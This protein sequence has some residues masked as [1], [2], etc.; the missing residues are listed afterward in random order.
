MENKDIKNIVI[1]TRGK[2][3]DKFGNPYRAFKAY[4][5]TKKSGVVKTVW[6]S[7][8]VGNCTE[9]DCREWAIAC[10]NM[11]LEVKI[12]KDDKRIEQHHKKVS[13]DSELEKPENW[14]V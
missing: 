12:T 11:V 10:I 8:D 6:K 14:R 1:Y 7:M 3:R 5:F 4:V 9:S 13:R 2:N